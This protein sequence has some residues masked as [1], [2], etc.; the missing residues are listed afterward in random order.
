MHNS[1]SLISI[2][3]H[4]STNETARVVRDLCMSCRVPVILFYSGAK[5][6]NPCTILVQEFYFILFY[7][8]R[9][10]HL[11][12]TLTS[13]DRLQSS[14][15]NLLTIPFANIT[16]GGRSF[17][18][19]KFVILCRQLCAL[20]TVPT[21]STGT[22]KLTTS[23]NPFHPLGTSLLA[24]PNRHLLTLQESILTPWTEDSK[25][26]NSKTARY[27]FSVRSVT[28]FVLFWFVFFC[29]DLYYL[30]FYHVCLVNKYFHNPDPDIDNF[31]PQVHQ[32]I[33]LFHAVIHSTYR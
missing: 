1:C 19:Q 30:L 33:G 14:N 18:V 27:V 28:V 6:Q 16:L 13:L 26:I 5:W 12:A 10:N 2:M 8:K 32:W 22:S 3:L 15:T 25:T 4:T 11:S 7:C 31:T 21:L 9:A 24:P 23:S 29:F 20:V 17:S